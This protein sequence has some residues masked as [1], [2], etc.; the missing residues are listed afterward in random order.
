VGHRYAAAVDRAVY[1]L[2]LD[3]VAVAKR[4]PPVRIYTHEIRRV[5]IARATA[6]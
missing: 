2:L 1:A 6:R 5:V 3:E 4:P